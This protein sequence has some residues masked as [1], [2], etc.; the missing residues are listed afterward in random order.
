MLQAT[1][2]ELNASRFTLHA[3]PHNLVLDL[4]SFSTGR[5]PHLN[6][7]FLNRL[8]ALGLVFWWTT[9]STHQINLDASFSVP[10]SFGVPLTT[11]QVVSE[12]G[13][14]LSKG[15][16]I[17]GPEDHQWDKIAKIYDPYF[18]PLF[19]MAVRPGD[20][21]DVS[22]IIQ[23][24]NHYDIPF[25]AVGRK[26]GMTVSMSKFEGIQIDM[27]L[28]NDII[29]N[30][31]EGTATFQGGVY[32][33]EVIETL[34]EQ[35][36]VTATGST[37]CVGLMGPALGGGRGRLEGF[38]GL[39]SDNFV[40]LNVVLANG[41]EVIVS[42]ASHPD[43]FWAMK[44]AGHN[45]GVV[46]SLTSKIYRRPAETFYYKI[47]TWTQDK[48]EILFDELN[49]LHNNGSHAKEMVFNMGVYTLD[50]HISKDE[51]VIV[52]SFIYAGPQDEAQVL[53]TPFD[54]L[55]PVSTQD[56][57]VPYTEIANV[58]GMGEDS[59]LCDYGLV[60]MHYSAGT[61]I[62]DVA[63]QREIYILFNRN[64]LERPEFSRSAVV[65]EDYSHAGVIAID[66]K[67]S[68]YPWRDR[69][70]LN[71]ITVT[72]S[73]NSTLDAFARK[74]AR[75]TRDIWNAAQ[76]DLLPSTYVNYAHGDESEESMYGYEPW[77]LQKLRSLK[78]LYDPNGRFSYYNPI[79]PASSQLLEDS[80]S[81]EQVVISAL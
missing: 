49:K 25:L 64:V 73:P 6:M 51:A 48:L 32:A 66:P 81:Q 57:N 45:F 69:S 27:S 34:W 60:H 13:P 79:L 61:Q 16:R 35:G 41:T 42:Q 23:Y 77:R 76:P 62:W 26:H 28:L 4:G 19:F 72:Y 30:P 75:Q 38:Y 50:P 21:N 46:T 18:Q 67:T 31:R 8:I 36:Y 47:Y 24:A 1:Q 56:G 71:F 22:K 78:A 53:L 68:S 2:M 52:W 70:L 80:R 10:V 63:A 29:I 3:L 5:R 9:V 17:I 40:E 7:A 20:K 39:I 43:L 14:Q 65:M 54:L 11:E 15:S 33:K 59:W 58:C 44:G 12:L 74:W 37:S 55:G